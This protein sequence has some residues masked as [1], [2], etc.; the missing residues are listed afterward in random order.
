VDDAERYGPDLRVGREVLIMHRYAANPSADDAAVIIS[1]DSHVGPRLK[2]ELRQYC[3]A[4]HLD[5]FDA[6]TEEWLENSPLR[7][8]F[9]SERANR[10]YLLEHFDETRATVARNVLT[11][12]AWDPKA[13]LEDMDR[14][15]IAADIIFHGLQAGDVA[16]LPFTPDLIAGREDWENKE[17]VALGRHMYNQWL[18]DFVSA[19]PERFAGLAQLP[20]W[21]IDAAIK[22]VRWAHDAGLRGINFPRSR[23]GL[24]PYN[25]PDWE[26]F[27]AV[28]EELGM[29]LS[30]HVQGAGVDELVSLKGEGVFAV[31][32]LE[33]NGTTARQSTHQMV[34]GGVFERHPN[35][36][37][38]F[39]EQTGTWWPDLMDSMDEIAGRLDVSN[40]AFRP[41]ED[42]FYTGY[43]RRPSDYAKNVFM[44]GS[45][46]AP[47]EAE[48]AIRLG[49]TKQ[50]MWG[51]DYPHT[52]GCWQY[53][54]YDGETP[55]THLAMRDT[56]GGLPYATIAQ[57]V[58][59]NAGRCYGFD[60]DHLQGV[61]DAIGAPTYGELATPLS[62]PPED[63]ATTTR[64]A[65][66][67]FRRQPRRT[68]SF[69]LS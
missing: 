69:Q 18:A 43:K 35:L 51:S 47:Y 56:F 19:A 44:G 65:F 32:L 45:F 52:E 68:E 3:P 22:E 30:T 50:V 33:I 61:A 40:S 8:M 20:M 63:P 39:T 6:F 41:K 25:H 62:E 55:M 48:D 16:P 67:A 54:R 26:P 59:G 5:Q 42:T 46:L 11:E 29:T 37:L 12:G 57:F 7:K 64:A 13:R 66:G 21:D 24:L 53:P 34:L 28:C 1:C 27:W 58:G 38:V 15:G 60:M 31:Q 4:S 17:L 14:D 49:Y 10:K 9:G 23:S 2:E 36:N